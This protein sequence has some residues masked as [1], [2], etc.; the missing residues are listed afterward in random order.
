MRLRIAGVVHNDVLGRE[1]LFKW[2][3]EVKAVEETPPAFVAVEYDEEIFCKIRAQRPILG[4]LAANV[5]PNALSSVRKAI[6]E[7]VAYEGDLH[8][9]VFPGVDTVWLDQGRTVSDPTIISDYALDRLNIYKSFIPEGQAEL[10]DE[11]LL[12]MS[13]SAWDRGASPQPGRWERDIKFA[14]LIVDR[15][16]PE[17]SRWAIVIVGINHATEV[18]GHMAR[19]LRDQGIECQASELRP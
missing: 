2:F 4:R 19:L 7:S 17:V 10:G 5:W 12:H 9:T 6:E 15:S 16:L 3:Q 11:S 13:I 14:Q 18:E 1:R 8:E